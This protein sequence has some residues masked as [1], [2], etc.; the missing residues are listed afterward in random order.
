VNATFDANGNL[1]KSLAGT[2]VLIGGQPIP[3]LY[4]SASQIGGIAPVSLP[5]GMSTV[6][7]EYQGAA[8][9]AFYQP[10]VQAVPGL[11]TA[12]ASGQ[13]QGAIL[14]EDGSI[15]SSSHPAAPGSV[16]SIY[17][18]GCGATNPAGMDGTIATSLEPLANPMVVTIGNQVAEL[19][20]A[21]SA[22][23]LVNG[24]VQINA[25]IPAGITGDAVFVGVSVAGSF[26]PSPPVTVAVH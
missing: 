18:S 10:V 15:N 24:A 19:L 4:T 6:Q 23:G 1:P 8:T 17:C 13:G 12:N 5:A 11:F 22:P 2:R 3:L 26:P 16:I 21:G 14:N 25:R 20:Y 7:V 9:L